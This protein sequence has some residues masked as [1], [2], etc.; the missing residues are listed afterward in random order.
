MIAAEQ[1]K[2]IVPDHGEPRIGA[3]R[4]ALGNGHRIVAAEARGVCLGIA[5]ERLPVGGAREAPRDAAPDDLMFGK[6]RLRTIIEAVGNGIETIESDAGQL[7]PGEQLGHA[8]DRGQRRQVRGPCCH[9][10][11][12]NRDAGKAGQNESAQAPPWLRHF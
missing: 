1:V 12:V 4:Q 8:D 11:R 2:P 6:T 9:D 10:L 3:N 5:Q 7:V